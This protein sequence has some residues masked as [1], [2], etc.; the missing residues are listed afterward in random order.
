MN[1]SLASNKYKH[2]QP[3]RSKVHG[4]GGINLTLSSST[5]TRSNYKLEI[6]TIP[7]QNN[8]TAESIDEN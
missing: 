7:T 5:N 1:I 8:I 4:K 2:N 3:K 6:S